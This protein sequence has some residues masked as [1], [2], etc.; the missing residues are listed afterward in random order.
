M[1]FP[2]N[3][4]PSDPAIKEQ[5]AST[6]NPQLSP[7]HEIEY[8]KTQVER[9]YMITEALWEFAKDKHGFDDKDLFRKVMEIDGRD[10]R[11]DGKV[12]HKPVPCPEC[13][14]TLPRNKAFC[15]YC[16]TYVAKQVFEH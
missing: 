10:G 7:E 9:L 16:G 11:I 13:N 6:P 3:I 12:R 8:L 15:L 4:D 5:V 14:H 2:S 1:I